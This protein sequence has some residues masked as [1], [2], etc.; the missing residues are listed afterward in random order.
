VHHN[1]AGR[2]A[3]GLARFTPVAGRRLAREA[4]CTEARRHTTMARLRGMEW[5]SRP[6]QGR[7][8]VWRT[9]SGRP[10][11]ERVGRV[12]T[13]TRSVSCSYQ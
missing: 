10:I 7:V 6:F 4:Q 8:T 11:A 13:G 2:A 3:D 12:T 5:A 1:V 9:G